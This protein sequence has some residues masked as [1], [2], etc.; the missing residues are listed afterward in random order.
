MFDDIEHRDDVVSLVAL[1][2]LVERAHR[3][4]ISLPH[5]V[6]GITVEF[7]A[8]YSKPKVECRVEEETEAT[9]EV[10]DGRIS[11]AVVQ[12][13]GKFSTDT[14]ISLLSVDSLGNIVRVAVNARN[15]R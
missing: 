13:A 5:V 4:G 15:V 11:G 10:E 9:T 1:L 6:D 12:E 2:E 8:V 7:N 14:H 3:I